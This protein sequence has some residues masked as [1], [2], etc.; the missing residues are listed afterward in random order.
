M[1]SIGIFLVVK[2][3]SVQ[4]LQQGIENDSILRDYLINLGCIFV[5]TFG[6]FLA[7]VLVATYSG[8]NKVL[9][10]RQSF[11]NEVWESD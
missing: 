2:I 4:K 8:N 3:D 9:C 10:H 5:R 11:E 6:N 1:Y 7:S